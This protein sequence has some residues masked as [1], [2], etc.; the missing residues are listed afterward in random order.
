MVVLDVACGPGYVS[1]VAKKMGA[2]PTGVDFSKKMVEIAKKMY[3]AI[4]FAQRDAQ[5]LPF[6]PTSFDRVL[7]NFGLLH[8]SHPEKACAETCH[9]I[10]MV[11]AK[12]GEQFWNRQALMAPR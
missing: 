10:C 3:P 1:A 4:R 11:K 8:L 12:N 2:N 6:G 5:N 7:I 9:I